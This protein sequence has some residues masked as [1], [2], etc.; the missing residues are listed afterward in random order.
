MNEIT[1]KK[2]AE[3]I[4]SSLSQVADIHASEGWDKKVMSAINQPALNRKQMSK[5]SSSL[6]VL[7]IVANTIICSL[8]LVQNH[9]YSKSTQRQVE[10]ER[11]GNE[12]RLTD[13][14]L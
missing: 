5:G 7:L 11:A 2:T 3:D 9:N 12:L 6:L 1:S 4:I 8:A 10:L 13:I 14:N